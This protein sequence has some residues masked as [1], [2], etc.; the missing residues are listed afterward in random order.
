MAVELLMTLTV[1]G[2]AYMIP[3]EMSETSKALEREEGKR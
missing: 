2:L 3:G 1:F